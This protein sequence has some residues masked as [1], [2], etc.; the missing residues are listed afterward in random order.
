VLNDIGHNMKHGV[1]ISLE[2]TVAP[3]TTDHLARPILEEQS[4]LRVGEGFNLVFS[5]E[6]VMVGRL[7]HNLTQYDRIVGGVTDECTRRGIELYRH[8]VKVNLHPTDALTAEVAKVTENAYRDV[9]IAFANEVALICESL[10]VNVHDV[11]RFVNSLPNDPSNPSANPIRN[12]HMPGAGVGGHCLPKDS[13]LLKYGL[14][15]YGSLKFNP[16]IIV[17]SRLLN[18][19]MPQ[20]MR[21]LTLDALKERNLDS[22]N[23]D[24]SILGLA[25]LENSDDTRNTP[26]LPLYNLLKAECRSIIV[27]DP[28][29]HEYETVNLTNSLEEATSE[30]DCLILVTRH[31]EY[32]QLT[33][34]WLKEKMRTP[35]VV[36]GRNAFNQTR[37][38]SQ[39][40]TFR[41]VGLPNNPKKTK[42]TYTNE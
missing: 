7:L 26:T 34:E 4:K 37:F 13:W 32:L 23:A 21:E 29:I 10:G 30:K 35:I 20:H 17:G 42:E 6:R 5:P 16:D 33:P 8:I 1:L 14:D 39:G 11:R 18:D 22:E 41:G 25:F 24:I 19:R 38:T 12:M 28:H 31:R 9:N 27:H 15:N 40:F 36:D 2:S 3:G